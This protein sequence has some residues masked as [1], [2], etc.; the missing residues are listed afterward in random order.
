MQ[1]KCIEQINWETGELD[2]YLSKAEVA[3]LCFKMNYQRVV[4]I[5]YLEKNRVN[6][7]K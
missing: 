1:Y 6:G 3:T 4:D 7:K 5:S 2:P